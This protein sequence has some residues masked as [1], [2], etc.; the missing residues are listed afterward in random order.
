MD[1]GGKRPLRESTIGAGQH[2]MS[3]SAAAN[4]YILLAIGDGLVAQIPALLIS[5]SLAVVKLVVLK[6]LPFDNKSEFQVIIDM[7]EGTTL[8]Q[9]K[10]IDSRT[11][12]LSVTELLELMAQPDG[13]PSAVVAARVAVA[14][15]A[16]ALGVVGVGSL[17]AVGGAA[18]GAAVSVLSGPV[19][20]PAIEG[21]KA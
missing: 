16:A 4:N 20:K 3:F 6:M 17:F 19:K 15:E 13:E 5:V 8:E 11:V 9:L 10:N 21:S 12:S 2:G 7:P 14:S 18:I 1:L